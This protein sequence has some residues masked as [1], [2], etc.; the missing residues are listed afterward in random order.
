MN[1]ILKVWARSGKLKPVPLQKTAFLSL[2]PEAGTCGS[3]LGRF[4][5]FPFPVLVAALLS[6]VL[7]VIYGGIFT[8]SARYAGILSLF[9]IPGNLSIMIFWAVWGSLKLSARPVSS[10]AVVSRR[11]RN[12]LPGPQGTGEK[13]NQ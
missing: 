1:T 7:S 6:G 5:V 4:I 2:I 13:G 8:G 3:I 11:G 9:R 10:P 12:L